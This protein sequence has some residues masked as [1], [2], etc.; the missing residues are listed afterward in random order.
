[1]RWVGDNLIGSAVERVHDFGSDDVLG[2]GVQGV[3]VAL[4]RVVESDS[5]VAEL[6]EQGGR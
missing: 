2:R 3:G 5:G 1:M 6:A 4:D